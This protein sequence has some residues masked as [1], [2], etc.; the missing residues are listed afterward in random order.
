MSVDSLEMQFFQLFKTLI[1]FYYL[2]FLSECYVI[3]DVTLQNQYFSFLDAISNV[4]A[5]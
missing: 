1:D 2:F 4:S 5:K 3:V